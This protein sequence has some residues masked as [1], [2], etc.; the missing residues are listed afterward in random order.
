MKAPVAI[1]ENMDTVL[2][3][4]FSTRIRVMLRVLDES[5]RMDMQKALTGLYPGN[6]VLSFN[7]GI[8]NQKIVDMVTK[9]TNGVPNYQTGKSVQLGEYM[10]VPF[11][12]TTQG[13][14]RCLIQ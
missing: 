14:S 9:T 3:D 2:K 12:K 11:G 6:L 4:P 13:R 10:C 7:A 1:I 5:S 8:M